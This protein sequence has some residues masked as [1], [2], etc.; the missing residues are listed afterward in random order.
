[1]AIPFVSDQF[2][3]VFRDYNTAVW[4]VQRILAALRLAALLA[5]A[6]RPLRTLK[7]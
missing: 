1:M 5:T 3:G 2:Y 4:P 6:R 7:P